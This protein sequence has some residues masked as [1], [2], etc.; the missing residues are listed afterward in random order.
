MEKKNLNSKKEK[1]TTTE[2]GKQT[3]NKSQNSDSSLFDDSKLKI[4][5]MWTELNSVRISG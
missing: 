2:F 5:V 4:F 1:K 3:E